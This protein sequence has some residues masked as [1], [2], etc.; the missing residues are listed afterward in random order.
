MAYILELI[1]GRAA[2]EAGSTAC[3]LDTNSEVALGL[4]ETTEK[5]D[6]FGWSQ[7]LSDAH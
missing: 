2:R 6:R 1:L 5:R 7:K 4:K 3:V